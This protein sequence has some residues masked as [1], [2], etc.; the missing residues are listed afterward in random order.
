[1]CDASFELGTTVTL[2]ATPVSGFLF[3]GWNGDCSGAGTCTLDMTQSR[4]V[5]AGFVAE[6]WSP[7]VVG[8]TT[9][10]LRFTAQYSPTHPRAGEAVIFQFVEDDPD[11]PV[12]YVCGFSTFGDGFGGLGCPQRGTRCDPASIYES[13]HGHA[14]QTSTHTYAMPGSYSLRFAFRSGD[15]FG[16]N[17]YGE[18]ASLSFTIDVALP[19]RTGTVI[20]YYEPDLDHFFLSADPAEQAYVDS[21]GAG[22]WQ[23]T[24]NMFGAGGIP[25]CR[26]YGNTNA[27]PATGAMYGPNSHFYT[28]DSGECA[29]L[30]LRYNAAEK[31]WKFEGNGFTTTPAV[32]GSCPPGLVAVYRAYN[33]GFAKGID[34][35]HRITANKAAYDT[36]VAKGWIGEGVVMCAPLDGALNDTGVGVCGDA[37]TAGCDARYGRDAAA[38]AGKLAK[39]GGGAAGF[40]FTALN[41]QGLPTAPSPGP[42]PHAC[43]R[44]N[45]TGLIWEVKTAD[46]GLHDM[47][48]KYSWYDSVHNYGDNPGTASGGACKTTGRCDTEKYV[49]DVNA[50]ALCGYT[51]W[52]MPAAM[53]LQGIEHFGRASPAID[54]TYFP[55]TLP[56]GGLFV[57]YWS[58]S[59]S[60]VSSN[61]AWYLDFG[62]SQSF[63]LSRSAGFSVRLV[64]GARPMP[65]PSGSCSDRTI[66]A[67][68]PDGAYSENGDGTVTDTRTGLMWKRC[69]E[70][71]TWNAGTCTGTASMFPWEGALGQA[72]T[73][74]FAGHSD[75]RLPNVKELRTLVEE[76]RRGPAINSTIFPETP[77]SFFWSST[78]GI[79][80]WD[81]NPWV[82]HQIISWGISFDDG[83]T[84]FAQ[85]DYASSARLVRD[86]QLLGAFDALSP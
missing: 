47:K 73:T 49:A 81:G 55:N 6:D 56:E 22:R 40:D 17:P 53:E 25:V 51:D 44:D 5:S 39:V 61:S 34:S 70:G 38:A 59:S 75:W 9:G 62:N 83:R 41:A 45:V 4:G 72:A 30:K 31:S 67:S 26:F 69:A 8:Q 15:F 42:T 19:A 80:V 36:Q 78:P 28:V 1:V 79:Y 14:E 86:G 12:A 37:S 29:A 52:R 11:A 84:N 66:P 85:R 63:S 68:N 24:G 71:E 43:V 7:L 2:T 3:A 33:N 60:A 54:S 13:L 10:N 46:G 21:G 48:W 64:R 82:Q 20:E 35:N 65:N 27:D 23:R 18:D 57:S 74:H 16:C 76:C 50:I 77:S 58:G 32:S